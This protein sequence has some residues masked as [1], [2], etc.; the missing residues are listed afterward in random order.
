MQESSAD[1]QIASEAA[2]SCIVVRRILRLGRAHHLP[3]PPMRGPLLANKRTQRGPA[4]SGVLGRDVRRTGEVCTQTVSSRPLTDPAGRTTEA[5][6]GWT[7]AEV[8]PYLI[9]IPA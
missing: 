9:E 1:W 8:Q 3:T 7:V 6:L 4:R 5:A 2:S